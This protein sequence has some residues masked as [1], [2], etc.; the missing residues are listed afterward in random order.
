MDSCCSGA[1][2]L[3][4][5]HL[6]RLG[7][8]SASLLAC[9]GGIL[10]H[11]LGCPLNSILLL[12]HSSHQ[13]RGFH[14]RFKKQTHSTECTVAVFTVLTPFLCVSCGSTT[15]H[16]DYVQSSQQVRVSVSVKSRCCKFRAVSPVVFS[17]YYVSK[18]NT[19]LRFQGCFG[20]VELWVLCASPKSFV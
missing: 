6:Q 10:S 11:V 7:A 14:Q 13:T 2:C 17:N 1:P 3:W 19:E 4:W 5:L 12:K 20:I 18:P 8:C 9:C 16:C 15:W